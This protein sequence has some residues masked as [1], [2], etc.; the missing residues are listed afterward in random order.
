MPI[1]ATP[2]Y[3]AG[4]Y[5][6]QS[7][8]SFLPV[9]ALAPQQNERVLDMASAPGKLDLEGLISS[10]LLV[11]I[12]SYLIFQLPVSPFIRRQNHT[13][14]CLDEKYWHGVC[15]RCLQGWCDRVVYIC[16]GVYISRCS[17]FFFLPLDVSNVLRPW[18]R[19]SIAS[20]APIQSCATTTV[21]TSPRCEKAREIF[22]FT[23]SL[24]ASCSILDCCSPFQGPG[25]L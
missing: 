17:P 9:M 12:L 3:L 2:E 7:A 18:W 16:S 4:H 23:A 21:V 5:I 11:S 15:Q 24:T 8:S 20:V 25:R 6:I 10:V 14:L 22:S 19:I 13:H 1:G